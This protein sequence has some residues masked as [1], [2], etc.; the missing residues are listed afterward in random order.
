MCQH[1]SKPTTSLKTI[2]KWYMVHMMG[3]M[4]LMRTQTHKLAHQQQMH[5]QI[6]K[7]A[8]HK[9]RNSHNVLWGFQ[10]NCNNCGKWCHRAA[11]C[12]K[13][14]GKGARKSK[15]KGKVKG[16]KGVGD[17]LIGPDG[18]NTWQVPGDSRKERKERKISPSPKSE[19]KENKSEKG[20]KGKKV[21]AP[22]QKESK[23]NKEKG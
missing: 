3:F 17:G 22:N 6:H 1:Q 10:G 16:G 4:C 5:K 8:H 14:K 19:R 9:Q 21:P 11:D 20:K 23:T 15:G 12:W 18:P 2:K 13:G 7:L